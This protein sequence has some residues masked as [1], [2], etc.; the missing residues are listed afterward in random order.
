M[1]IAT[2]EQQVGRHLGVH[3]TYFNSA[4]TNNVIATARDD[5]THHRLT[6]ASIKPP[7]TWGQVAAGAYDSWLNGLIRGLGGL[8]FPVLLC[9]NHEPE[10]DVGGT[11]MKPSDWVAMY[12][13]AIDMGASAASLTFVPILMR[14]TFDPRS[15]RNPNDWLVAKSKV[16]GI[17]V[18]NDW[19]PTDGLRWRSFQDLLTVVRPWAGS[20]PIVVAEYGV[21]NDP[22][23]SGR[24][25]QWMKDAYNYS[26]SSGISVMSYFDSWQNSHFGAWTLD[27]ERLTAFKQILASSYNA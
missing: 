4:Q 17:D 27:G 11:G 15:G 14:W 12:N 18:Y 7:G 8:G 26:K 13:R 16:F 21:H 25:A 9:I 20:K 1:S 22:S 23:Q 6:L 5:H 10:N 3:R 2:F 19:S 24:A